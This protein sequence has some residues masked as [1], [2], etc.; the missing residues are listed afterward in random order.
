MRSLRI[1]RLLVPPASCALALMM[2]APAFAVPGDLDTSFH[3]TGKVETNFGSPNDTA[4]GV[5]IQADGKIVAAG[6][7]VPGISPSQIS[8]AR[9]Q[10]KG[11]LDAS[12]SGRAQEAG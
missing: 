6:S 12:F 9:Y 5:A 8:V 11:K 7:L 4:Q 10:S 1:F 3:H 2:T